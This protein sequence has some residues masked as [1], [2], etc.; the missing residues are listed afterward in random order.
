MNTYLDS[1]VIVIGGGL[2]GLVCA[3]HLSNC[4][5]AVLVIEKNA[6]P[7]HKVCGEYVSNEVLPYLKYLGVDPFQLGAKKIGRLKLSSQKNKTIETPLPLGGFGISRYTFDHALEQK[8]KNNGVMIIRD[9]VVDI[10]FSDGAF[11]VSTNEKIDYCAKIVIGAFG[12]RS[13]L[14]VKLKRDFIK[15]EAPFLA[16]KT[17][18][19]GDFPDD[20]V[21]LH[22][23]RGGYCGA[24]KVENDHINLCYITD[25]KS[26]KKFKNIRDFQENVLF[27]N[28]H[29]KAIFENSEPVFP[30]PLCI[31]QISFSSKDPVERHILMCGDTAGMIHPLCGNGMSMAIRGAQM[32]S[33]LIIDYFN[34]RLKLRAELEKLYSI[35]WKNEFA[36]RL[37]T[38]GWWHP[39]FG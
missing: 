26:F 17:H 32:A 4:G 35:A 13:A 3:I 7:Q 6:Y 36:K 25:F 14:D 2:A 12:K 39:F 22:N 33:Q 21:A 9:A 28:R 19:K 24:S 18:V 31:S 11:C 30:K 23:F 1:E 16:V 38:G 15:K 10:E 8:A 29:L 34:G 5:V 20:L 37:R 27:Q